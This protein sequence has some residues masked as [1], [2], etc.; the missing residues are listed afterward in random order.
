MAEERVGLVGVRPQRGHELVEQG[1]QVPRGRF[2]A[3]H[4]APGQPHR[5]QFDL[6]G[7]VACLPGGYGGIGEAIA[8]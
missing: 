5:A 1:G 6:R 2:G 8:W 7:Q 3:A 4:L